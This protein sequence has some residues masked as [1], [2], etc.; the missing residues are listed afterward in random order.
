MR[1]RDLDAWRAWAL[2]ILG[3]L[4]LLALAVTQVMDLRL[5]AALGWLWL[6][7]AI[8]WLLAL[9]ATA[10]ARRKRRLQLLASLL[11]SLREGDYS[12]RARLKGEAFKEVW[13]EFNALAAHLGGEQRFGIETNALLA[14]LL[15]AL[16][17]A[18][19]VVDE[20][21]RLVDLN[22][23][24][25]QL[26]GET[27]T[28]LI[29]RSAGE[30]RLSDWLTRDSPFMDS[31]EF[32]GGTGPWEVRALTFRRGGRPHH[33]VVI[34]DVSRA[35]REEERRVWRRLVRVL[36]HEI[37]NSLGPIQSTANLLKERHQA[38]AGLAEGL[39]LIE[40]RSQ[41]LGA[42][43]RRYA[44]LARLPPPELETVNLAQLLQHVVSLETRLAVR[45]ESDAQLTAR[46]DPD[47]L[48]QALINLVRNATDAALETGG[49]VRVRGGAHGRHAVIEIE[50]DGP[51]IAQAE[52][53]FVPFYTTKPGGSGI[54]LVLARQILEAHGG[55]LKLANRRDTRGTI[56]SL[57]LPI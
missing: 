44:D 12:L 8:I 53:L 34:T 46:A 26:L 43:I 4:P 39:D 15:A 19:L 30:L 22:P 33:L 40:R 13:H 55:S 38:D 7:L 1:I 27:A 42:F 24:A 31:R 35:L 47:Q 28:A 14:Q 21:E 49:G 50:D 11:Q 56:A 2:G 54:G 5:P 6:A 36:G 20:R 45:L 9:L 25:E 17:F 32:A 48:E 57:S 37:N 3:A 18:V 41:A 52:N 29:G 16:D 10:I 23:A 51:G